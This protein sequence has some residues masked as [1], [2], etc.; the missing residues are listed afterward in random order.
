M[1]YSKIKKWIAGHKIFSSILGLFIIFFA[2]YLMLGIFTYI[3]GG[4]LMSS[5][6]KISS[7]G[8]FESAPSPLSI[9]SFSQEYDFDVYD[10]EMGD[11]FEA[12]FD[13]RGVF[14]MEVKE[15][16]IKIDSDNAKNDFNRTQEIIKRKDGYI[17]VNRKT[18][19]SRLLT[20]YLE[21]R[22]PL[23]HFDDF[24]QEIKNSFETDSYHT[25]NYRIDVRY[26]T[27]EIDI[28]NRALESYEKI[29]EEA[30]EIPAGAEKIDLLRMIT[31]EETELVRSQARFQR[32]LAD[33]AMQSDMATVSITIEEEITPALWPEDLGSR[34]RDKVNNA[35]DSIL[36]SIMNILVNS[37]ILVIKVIEYLLYALIIIIPVLFAWR[38]I[39]VFRRKMQ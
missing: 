27:D 13:S 39:K 9:P 15:G 10:Y 38:W 20:I 4:L 1:N 17:E 36:V 7:D 12:E 37:L 8:F 22:I 30:L 16:R 23:N 11:Y 5:P 2:G 32:D 35:I 3:G 34:F 18:E 19:T 6:S 14:E 29:R 28:I 33:R 26:Q 21:A 25:S 24:V 31:E